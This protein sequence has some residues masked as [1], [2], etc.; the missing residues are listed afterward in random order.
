MANVY[1]IDRRTTRRLLLAAGSAA[2]LGLGG[3]NWDSYLDPSV[4]GR[5]EWTPTSVPV[6]DRIA[7]IE[8]QTGEGIDFAD[9]TPADLEPYVAHVVRAFGP[10]RLMWGSDWPVCLLAAPYARV[11]E[12][13]REILSRHLSAEDL[14]RVFTTNARRVYRI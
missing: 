7:S 2:S 4:T 9:P 8:D 1:R 14:E 5:W 13:A 11:L 10:D 12:V 6:L 3:C